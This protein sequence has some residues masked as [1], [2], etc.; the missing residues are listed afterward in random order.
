MRSPRRQTGL[1]L[2]ELIVAIV[3]I[4]ITV[5]S[6]LGLLTSVA[7]QSADSMTQTQSIAIARSYLEEIL[8]KPTTDPDAASLGTRAQYDDIQDYS[9]L[10]DE[11]PRT[12]SGALM[13]GLNQYRVTVAIQNNVTLGIAPDAVGNVTRVT[14]TV[15]NPVGTTV[16]LI[17]YRTPHNAQVV[18]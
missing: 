5:M 1:T 8:A 6:M 12:R 18:Y 4:G 13:A 15:T 3:V 10:P 9:F 7:A 16:Q 14:V 17:G 11:L 2:I